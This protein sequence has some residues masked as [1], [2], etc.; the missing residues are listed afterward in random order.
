MSRVFWLLLVMTALRAEEPMRVLFLG[1]S[2][3][4]YNNLPGLVAAYRGA[5]GDARRGDAGAV[6]R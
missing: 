2:Y 4:Y 6:V 3:T 1:N 5:G